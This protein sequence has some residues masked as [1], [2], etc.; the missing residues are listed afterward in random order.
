MPSS[1]RTGRVEVKP[2]GGPAIS[3][4]SAASK[5]KAMEVVQT[6]TGYV[7]FSELVDRLYARP[8]AESFRQPVFELWTEDAVPG[9]REII[10]TP[11]DLGTIKKSL[12][13]GLY[14]TYRG[15]HWELDENAVER[16]IALAFQNCMLYNEEGSDLYNDAKNLLNLA[17]E[18]FKERRKE[19]E[20][21]AAEK[22]RLKRERRAAQDR[23]RRARQKKE[24]E[25]R[26]ALLRKKEEIAREKRRIKEKERKEKQRLE[27]L[28]QE[29][30]ERARREAEEQRLREEA[31]RKVREEDLE[32]SRMV[33]AL[34]NGK[35]ALETPTAQDGMQPGKK[36]RRRAAD[37]RSTSSIS[38]DE[39]A[40]I[41]EK[42]DLVETDEVRDLVITFVSTKGLDK[43]RGRKSAVAQRLEAEHEDLMRKRR[44][45]LDHKAEFE[46]RKLVEMTDAEK[47]EIC[48]KVNTASFIVMHEIC[49]LIA[50]ELNDPSILQEVE[51]D[52]D[53]AQMSNDSLREMQMLLEDPVRYKLKGEMPETEKKLA[54]IEAEYIGLRYQPSAR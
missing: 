41:E 45:I 31:E 23:E 47:D 50:A 33:M 46:K 30:E 8:E 16:D 43:K 21:E 20:R 54:D 13:D 38:S 15:N 17:K 12:R 2:T 1:E 11:M 53:L 10:E 7:F 24:R 29:E 32:R 35:R 3:S 18:N 44:L 39:A 14:N 40:E 26:E 5:A 25:H 28:K 6:S 49:K 48:K 52:V 9:Y 36:K 37:E 4:R 19:R 42:M 22:D 27:K 34:P 51:I